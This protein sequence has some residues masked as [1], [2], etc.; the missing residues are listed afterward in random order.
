MDWISALGAIGGLTGIASAFFSWSEWQKTNR[1]IAMLS[2]AS[3]AAEILPAWYTSRMMQDYW[4]F[5]LVMSDGS[6]IAI[7]A[8]VRPQGVLLL[9]LL[10]IIIVVDIH[11]QCCNMHTIVEVRV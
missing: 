10:T 8:P 2:D 7:K 3:Q 11:N 4:L 1:K 6:V 5:G 9:L